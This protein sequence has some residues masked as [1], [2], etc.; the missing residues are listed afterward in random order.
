MLEL[1]ILNTMCAAVS[2]AASVF[3][4]VVLSLLFYRA[5]IYVLGL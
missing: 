1:T 4:G 5:L 2:F 3:L